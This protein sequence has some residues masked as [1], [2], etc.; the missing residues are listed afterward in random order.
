MRLWTLDQLAQLPEKQAVQKHFDRLN[1]RVLRWFWRFSVLVAIGYFIARSVDGELIRLAAAVLWLG[2]LAAMFFARTSRFYEEHFPRILPAF[3][4]GTA[5]CM[6]VGTPNNEFQRILPTALL[7][8]TLLFFRMQARHCLTV[9]GGFLAMA[10]TVGLSQLGGGPDGDELIVVPILLNVMFAGAS[11]FLSRQARLAFL[12]EW[13]GSAMRERERAR[14][15]GELADARKIQLAMLPG[16]TPAVDWLTIASASQPASEVG[17]DFYDHFLLPDG[18]VALAIGDVAG[19]G[20]GSGLV[21]AGIKSG[22]HLL[23]EELRNPVAVLDRLNRLASEWLQWRMLVTLLIAV[24]DPSKRSVRV[25]AAGHAPLIII[26]SGGASRRIGSPA[27]PLGTKLA[28]SW[29]ETSATLEDG[30]LLVF[31]TDGLTELVDA[32]GEQFGDERL[33]SVV[34]EAALA[35]GGVDSIRDSVLSQLQRFRGDAPQLDDISVVVARFRC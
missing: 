6:I 13:T 12:E 28:P 20:V 21:L 27:L 11:L 3:L 17:G 14:M 33:E 16:A 5:A 22:L 24:V 18:S 34:R 1:Y 23:R 10:V 7:P 35:G 2:V 19:H 26:S 32:T 31:C 9:A 15:T 29:N 8:L 4:L 25:A 30:D